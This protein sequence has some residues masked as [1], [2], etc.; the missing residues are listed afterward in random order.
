MNSLP[1][2]WFLPQKAFQ[3]NQAEV[4]WTFLP[5]RQCHTASLLFHSVDNK[6]VTKASPDLK[7]VDRDSAFDGRNV[8]EIETTLEDVYS[9]SS[10]ERDGIYDQQ[11][12]INFRGQAGI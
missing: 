3:E 9:W 12:K 10:K 1:G 2:A 5:S 4:A 7:G 6:P 11:Y 8:K